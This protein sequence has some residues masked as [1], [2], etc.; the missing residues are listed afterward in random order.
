MW[1]AYIV[2]DGKKIASHDDYTVG[3]YHYSGSKPLPRK[4]ETVIFEVHHADRDV[5]DGGYIKDFYEV[6][7]INIIHNHLKYETYLICEE[8]QNVEISSKKW[9]KTIE[10]MKV[11]LE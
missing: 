7:V 11:N 6:K 9:N 10:K 2:I 5:A 1:T 8:I 4:D 3:S